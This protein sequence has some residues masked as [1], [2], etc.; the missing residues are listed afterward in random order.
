VANTPTAEWSVVV[1][2]HGL[3][4]VD[5]GHVWLFD[6]DVAVDGAAPPPAGAVVRLTDG[7]G[8][9]HGRGFYSA[10][11]RI[12]VRVATRGGAAIDDAWWEARL[13]AAMAL[14]ARLL[15]DEGAVRLINAEGDGLPGVVVDRYGPVAVV[16][17]TT[18]A[19]DARREWLAAHLMAQPGIAGVH[20]R[21]DGRGR[22]LEGLPPRS[23]V[24]MGVVPDDVAIDDGGVTVRV[25]PRVGH[26]TGVYLDQRQNRRRARA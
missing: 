4:R 10:R 6:T 18:P 17:L 19:A 3:T 1:S 22:T 21:S 9:V 23:G 8:R 11:S 16:Q 12:A 2:R 20:E 14:R 13:A 24:V 25:D 5:A 15:P 7:R 26:K